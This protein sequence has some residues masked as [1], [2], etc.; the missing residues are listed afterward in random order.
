MQSAILFNERKEDINKYLDFLLD[1]INNKT[2]S[3]EISHIMKANGYLMLYNL[4]E[5]TFTEIISD[6]HTALKSE[7]NLN[8]DKLKPS[9]AKKACSLT[10]REYLISYGEDGYRKINSVIFKSW[11]NNYEKLVSNEKNPLFSGN[12]DGKIIREIGDIYGFNHK[13]LDREDNA[14]NVIFGIKK[15]RNSLAHGKE[16]FLSHGKQKSI[17]SLKKEKELTI[18]YLEELLNEIAKYIKNKLY[19]KTQSR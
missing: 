5:S 12:I 17:D 6:I 8:I 14:M 15:A 16:S 19:L 10:D 18:N 4:I 11:L 1:S 7:R 3:N 9:L 2:I 13:T